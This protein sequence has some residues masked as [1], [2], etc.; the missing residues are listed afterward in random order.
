MRTK[1]EL[2]DILVNNKIDDLVGAA[3]W[4]DLVSAVTALTETEQTTLLGYIIMRNDVQAGFTLYTALVNEVKANA[5]TGANT[6]LN[7]DNLTL[8]ELD[9]VL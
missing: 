3:T 5:T 4:A 9:L 8:A 1:T 7:D 6:L 2:I